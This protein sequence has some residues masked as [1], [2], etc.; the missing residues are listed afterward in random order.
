MMIIPAKQFDHI[1]KCLSASIA[2]YLLN[3]VTFFQSV[4]LN[5]ASI[6]HKRLEQ[7]TYYKHAP[8]FFF[9][10]FQL[11]EQNLKQDMGRTSKK[12]KNLYIY[13]KTYLSVK[14]YEPNREE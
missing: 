5:K 4:K 3:G 9:L 6:T 1:S 7:E 13:I 14:Y 12:L 2:Y 11:I 8:L 10:I